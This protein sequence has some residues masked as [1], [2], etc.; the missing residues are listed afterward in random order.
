[1]RNLFILILL[2]LFS[3]CTKSQ[4]PV[5]SQTSVTSSLDTV[6]FTYSNSSFGIDTIQVVWRKPYKPP[7]PPS[8]NSFVVPVMNATDDPGGFGRGLNN[9]FSK[10]VFPYTATLNYWRGSWAQLQTGQT[11]YNWNDF[12]NQVKSCITAGIQLAFR[13]GILDNTAIGGYVTI[14]GSKSC[15]PAFVHTLMQGESTKD[16]ASG[17]TWYPNWNSQSLLNAWETFLKQLALHIQ[18]DKIN[19]IP[20]WTVIYSQDIGFFGNYLSEWN[21]YG[22]DD[23]GHGTVAT[24]ATLIRAIT[25]YQVIFPN[26]WLILNQATF[27][28][29]YCSNAVAF[30]AIQA[31][32]S[33]GYFGFRSDHAAWYKTTAY[34]QDKMNRVYN[35]VNFLT[36]IKKRRN[37]AP[38]M[39]EPMNNVAECTPPGGTPYQT[40][41]DEVNFYGYST[42]SNEPDNVPSSGKNNYMNSALRSG[43]RLQIDSGAY[44]SSNGAL[45][46]KLYYSSTNVAPVYDTYTANLE[47]RNGSNVV[48]KGVSIFNPLLVMGNVSI[49]DTYTGIPL[50]TYSLIISMKDPTNYKKP[51]SLANKNRGSDGSYFLTSITIK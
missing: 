29:R 12:D 13:V 20:I 19:N 46:L 7:I 2:L 14:N 37:F 47:L 11:T 10:Q 16:W 45:V 15:Y 30:A 28:L 22:I 44:S 41:I 49:G 39:A 27:D 38:C 43:Y 34:D 23:K 31:K 26:T 25:G 9:F 33:K 17:G 4:E 51:L 5:F 50:G 35:G 40:L 8:G 42:I 32:N 3:A 24:D 36:E 21:N 6:F 1:M 18:N 48:W